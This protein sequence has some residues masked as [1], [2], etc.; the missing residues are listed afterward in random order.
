MNICTQC[1]LPDTFPGI[2]FN[3]DG[4]CNHCQGYEKKKADLAG[5]KKRYQQKFIELIRQMKQQDQR[6]YD[7]IIAYSGGK[8]SSYTLMLLKKEYGLRV[9]AMTFDHGFMS[10][11]AFTNIR[12]M[13][14]ALGVDHIVLAPAGMVLINAFRKSM[15][16]DIYP[17]KA[18]ER[19]SA[20]CNTC[21]NL[22]K[23]SVL[24]TAIEMG[25]PFI[26]YGWSPG[27]APIASSVMKLNVPMIRQMQEA[28][29]RTTG[30]LIGDEIR[31]YMLNQRHYRELLSTHPDEAENV[32]LYAVHPLAFHEYHEK[33]IAEE[34]RKLGWLSPNDT[35][36]NSTN[37]LLNSLANKIHIKRYRF[38]PYAFEIA[39]LVREGCMTREEGLAKLLTPPDPDVMDIVQKKLDAPSAPSEIDVR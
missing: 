35:D 1:V 9:L 30:M 21:I 5:D 2:R 20:I 15:E 18:L 14:T 11:Q 16:T 4:V 29:W 13:T 28:M 19:A 6:P 33:S 34:I 31:P 3:D 27:Q 22:V 8:D 36:S 25:I 39:G 32:S 38:H 37:C 26:A 10:P 24:K 7:V 17:M 12:Q 23:S